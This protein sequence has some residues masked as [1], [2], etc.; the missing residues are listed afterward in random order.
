MKKIPLIG[1][2]SVVTLSPLIGKAILLTSGVPLKVLRVKTLQN[3]AVSEV[4]SFNSPSVVKG[5]RI[6]VKLRAVKKV[7]SQ[8]NLHVLNIKQFEK[9]FIQKAEL[10]NKI[11]LKNVEILAS[12]PKIL[13]QQINVLNRTRI[14]EALT[15]QPKISSLIYDPLIV[16]LRNRDLTD[17]LGTTSKHALSSRKFLPNTNLAV[18]SN[19]QL[20]VFKSFVS[21]VGVTSTVVK[22]ATGP[23]QLKVAV[24]DRPLKLAEKRF[25][26]LA[27]FKSLNQK[28]VLK[29]VS[30]TLGLISDIHLKRIIRFFENSTISVQSRV[31]LSRPQR[32]NLVF[33]S[34]ILKTV[35][36]TPKSNLSAS[37]NISKKPFKGFD[38]K[39][40]S[41]SRVTLGPYVFDSLSLGNHLAK[42]VRKDP[43]NVFGTVFS[44]VSKKPFKGFDSNVQSRSRVT[45]G[46]YIFDSIVFDTT[47]IKKTFKSFNDT[48]SLSTRIRKDVF[49]PIKTFGAVSS[50]LLT[51]RI[52]TTNLALFSKNV[53]KTI[54]GILDT[55]SLST[56]IRKDVF[57]PIKTF[58]AVS[59]RVLTSTL[60]RSSISTD[61]KV[62][63]HTIKGINDFLQFKNL[64]NKEVSKPDTSNVVF[65]SNLLF[66]RQYKSNVSPSSFL[67]KATV[68]DI[69]NRAIFSSSLIFKISQRIDPVL[70]RASS[71]VLRG[72]VEKSRVQIASRYNLKIQKQI[73]SNT[74]AVS[75]INKFVEKDGFKVVVKASD[76]IFPRKVLFPETFTQLV[77][78]VTKT[79][80][81]SNTD[82]LQAE[83]IYE[84]LINKKITTNTSIAADILATRVAFAVD[85]LV[86]SNTLEKYSIKSLNDLLQ[87]KNLISNTPAKNV[88]S[89]ASIKTDI[90]AAL[91]PLPE[92]LT[93]I[94]SSVSAF[95]IKVFEDVLALQNIQV[96]E[97]DKNLPKTILGIQ[98]LPFIIR[99]IAPTSL[100]SLSVTIED[101]KDVVKGITNKA[102]LSTFLIEKLIKRNLPESTVGL[103]NSGLLIRPTYAVNYF[104]DD[105]EGEARVLN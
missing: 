29:N 59:S 65:S 69:Q 60:Q 51:G 66:G 100:S 90:L 49:K 77:S 3:P 101:V 17:I 83:S 78:D 52:Y 64:L 48:N 4:S 85:K 43:F 98:S 80:I 82:F 11:E 63:K 41:R 37:S 19:K 105:Y 67:R 1:V 33:S 62:I 56:R 38:S 44:Q 55:N 84:N 32:S 96:K 7:N 92:D 70:F 74:Q 14:K 36:K 71:F 46:P 24:T 18:T 54:K 34:A 39:V 88:K 28:N 21:P 10:L 16:I 8:P 76:D 2:K 99:Y 86:L 53:K 75:L 94:E 22:G 68:K 12:D 58:G 42:V 91:G 27:S 30:N 93:S 72:R 89:Q 35:L 5:L 87:I 45:L 73:I 40:Q 97:V 23:K 15:S 103:A 25:T 26:S 47:N 13:I 61:I 79:Q 81:K 31:L 57:K 9:P 104:I 95:T 50:R 102:S 20:Q 6:G